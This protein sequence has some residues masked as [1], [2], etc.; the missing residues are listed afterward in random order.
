MGGDLASPGVP[1]KLV[2][3]LH[4]IDRIDRRG[5]YRG[6]TLVRPLS[7]PHKCELLNLRVVVGALE[8][9][10]W[11]RWVGSMHD[12][13][14]E[15]IDTR[16]PAFFVVHDPGVD[17]LPLRKDASELSHLKAVD[18]RAPELAG[19]WPRGLLDKLV[20]GL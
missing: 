8:F 6:G 7:C 19:L 15:R 4:A 5:A 12:L 16:N 14:L 9:S 10:R 13:G 17:L 18:D 3:V 20:R 1:D 11:G 2:P